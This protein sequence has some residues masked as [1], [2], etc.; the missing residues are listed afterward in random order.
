MVRL[1]LPC[2][3]AVW[4]PLLAPVAAQADEVELALDGPRGA[5][6]WWLREGP[7]GAVA[8]RRVQDGRERVGAGRWEGERVR[9]ELAPRAG[10]GLAGA[11]AAGSRETSAAERPWTCALARSDGRFRA[12]LEAGPAAW[13]ER[14]AALPLDPA[15][16]ARGPADAARD[17]AR[18]IDL[19]RENALVSARLRGLGPSER[20]GPLILLPG[21]ARDDFSDGLHPRAEA[22]A[23]RAAR[24]LRA[25]DGVAILVSGGNVHPAGTPWNEALQLKR[26]LRA[27]GVPEERIALEPFA[28][29]TTTNLRNAGRFMLAHGLERAVVVSGPGQSFYVSRWEI[30]T[31][32]AR[33]RREL[34]HDVGRLFPLGLHRTRFRPS[35]RCVEAGPDPLDP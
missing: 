9:L 21:Y 16:Y 22:R 29:H 6:R 5:A 12:A 17:G 28:R 1:R 31:F 8:V 14:G 4:L 7:D 27:L 2:S 10:P 24:A 3:L 20:A 23:R 11:L 25:L 19:V 30:T 34:G 15:R 13:E 18:P 32:D 33:C 26:A 35:P